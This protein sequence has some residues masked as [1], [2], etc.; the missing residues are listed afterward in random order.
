[1]EACFFAAFVF[2]FG[3]LVPALGFYLRFKGYSGAGFFHLM[4]DQNPGNDPG[5]FHHHHGDSGS[6]HG[7]GGQ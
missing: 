5:H 4:G 2:V 6:H 7:H 1:M 3:L